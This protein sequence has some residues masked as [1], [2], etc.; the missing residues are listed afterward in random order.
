MG[1]TGGVTPGATE[2][3]KPLCLWSVAAQLQPFCQK[4][5]AADVAAAVVEVVENPAHPKGRVFVVTG[6]GLQA[7]P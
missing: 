2:L 6:D 5:W 3:F 1:S 7:A 4:P